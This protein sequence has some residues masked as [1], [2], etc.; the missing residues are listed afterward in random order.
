VAEQMTVGGSAA[1]CH[2]GPLRQDCP[3]ECLQAILSQAPYRALTRAQGAPFPLPLTVADVIRLYVCRDL[4]G[5]RG[6]GPRRISEIE[7]ALVLV[8]FDLSAHQLP[9]RHPAAAPLTGD[10]DSLPEDPAAATARPTAGCPVC[11]APAD[12]PPPP[13]QASASPPP[14]PVQAAER[15]AR[16]LTW[17]AANCHRRDVTV[18]EVAGVAGVA[19]LSVRRLQAVFRRDMGRGPLRLMADMRMHR[20][21]LAL[22]GRAPAPASLAEAARLAGHSRVHRFRVAY[23]E[24]YGQYPAIPARPALAAAPPGTTEKSRYRSSPE[25]EEGRKPRR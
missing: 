25:P 23:R 17:M 16:V 11:G 3:V 1:V 4:R 8:G 19:G 2:H 21:H 13:P 10:T 20:V 14:R 5:I 22:T 18:A 12:F 9:P 6:L 15:T 24:R 7:T